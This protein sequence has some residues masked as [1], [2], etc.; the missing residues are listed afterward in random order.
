MIHTADVSNG[1]KPDSTGSRPFSLRNIFPPP[2]SDPF[3]A[4]RAA[5]ARAPPATNH[6]AE[7]RRAVLNRYREPRASLERIASE[8]PI[9]YGQNRN[10][11][12]RCAS[13]QE[14]DTRRGSILS[15]AAG[16][17]SPSVTVKPPSRDNT[18]NWTSQGGNRPLVERGHRV[19]SDGEGSNDISVLGGRRPERRTQNNSVSSNDHQAVHTVVDLTH[20][21]LTA[22]GRRRLEQG[23]QVQ[24]ITSQVQPQ[25]HPATSIDYQASLTVVE[26]THSSL[27]AW[28]RRRLEQGDQAPSVASQGQ[29]RDKNIMDYG[30]RNSWN[31][32]PP[33]LVPSKNDRLPM[34]IPSKGHARQNLSAPASF[35]P[36]DEPYAE[37]TNSR[38][39]ESS[40]G[41]SP[42]HSGSSTRRRAPSES[43][44]DGLEASNMPT[45]FHTAMAMTLARTG[46]FDAPSE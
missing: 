13:T 8:N 20:S 4:A 12:T 22:W 14:R 11:P 1:Q 7:A 43:S 40:N 35:K 28:G 30:Q 18:E 42:G 27:T 34:P 25:N 32:S 21:S 36:Q 10:A 23:G 31:G 44:R 26:S 15:W 45:S 3:D 46:R 38:E 5:Q 39:S 29:P 41:R 16:L 37:S 9:N 6:H 33:I 19:V 24:S 17:Q 2:N